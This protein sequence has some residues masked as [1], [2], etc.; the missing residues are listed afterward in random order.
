MEWEQFSTDSLEQQLVSDELE[1][2]RL[3]ARQMAVLAVVDA[4]Q[5][6]T[7]DGSRSLGEWVS[8]RL[9]VA[10]D[11]ARSLVRTMRRLQD[12]PDLHRVLAEGGVSFDRAEGLSRIQEDVGLLEHLDVGGVH[13]EAA[14]RVRISSEDEVRS[15]E[16]RFLVMQPSL[17]ESWWK[18]WF[19]LD[20]Y[21]GALVDKV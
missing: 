13:R 18:G 5:V 10:S 19:G 8:A 20:G 12:R 4:R 16:D 2:A 9:D 3:R 15:A 6:S 1:V 7:A 11:T 21:S 17:D 14:L